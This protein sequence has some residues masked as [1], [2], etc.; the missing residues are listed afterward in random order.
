MNHCSTRY[1]TSSQ[2]NIALPILQPSPL[3][4][5]ARL[6][7]VISLQKIPP[8]KEVTPTPLDG[9]RDNVS[10]NPYLIS[11]SKMVPLQSTHIVKRDI[12]VKEQ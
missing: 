10:P 4:P 1:S 3:P 5:V 9:C 7:P 6:T 8:S 2:T 11:H 12:K